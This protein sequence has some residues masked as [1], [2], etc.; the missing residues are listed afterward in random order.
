MSLLSNLS[1]VGILSSLFLM[2][3]MLGLGLTQPKNEYGGS[4]L[5]PEPTVLL[6]E[7]DRMP[8]ALGLVMVGFAGHAVFPS[9]YMSMKR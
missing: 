4:I 1:I 2:G 7:L 3:T 8:L 9:I 5:D 6:A